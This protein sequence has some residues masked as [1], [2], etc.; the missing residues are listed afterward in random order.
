LIDTSSPQALN[1]VWWTTALWICIR[2]A[3]GVLRIWPG[4]SA[5]PLRYRSLR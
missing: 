1:F 4:T 2:A 3:F 5:S